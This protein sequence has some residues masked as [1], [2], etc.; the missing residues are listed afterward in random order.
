MQPRP[1]QRAARKR[2]ARGEEDMAVIMDVALVRR[3]G[4]RFEL[5]NLE[6]QANPLQTEAILGSAGINTSSSNGIGGLPRGNNGALSPN[7]IVIDLDAQAF[8]DF[9]NPPEKQ[10]SQP[11]GSAS[12]ETRQSDEAD[13]LVEGDRQTKPKPRKPTLASLRAAFLNRRIV[14]RGTPRLEA[15]WVG[16]RKDYRRKQVTLVVDNADDLVVL[17]RFD[18][19]GNP[20][21]NGEFG[22]IEPPAQ[23]ATAQD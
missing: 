1:F 14:A 2:G 19:D 10:P 17:P 23:T 13:I 18:G 12:P 9:L 7:V 6:L 4:D 8:A 21:L 22:V 20:I 3:R 15:Q 11:L 5:L 16:G